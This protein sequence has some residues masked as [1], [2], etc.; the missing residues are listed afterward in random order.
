MRGL[1]EYVMTGRR[2]AI[3]IV[4]LCGFFPLL[5]YFSAAVVG[6]VTLRK[7]R[8][9][10]LM[11]LL[12]ALLPA[13]M[14]WA[15]GDT[16]LVFLALGTYGLALALRQ[17]ESWQLVLLAATAIGLV[18]QLS[19]AL[20][21]GYLAQI[22]LVVNDGLQA[23]LSQAGQGT[24]ITAQQ[25]IDLLVSFYGAYHAFMVVIC[26]MIARWWQALLY[27]PGGFRQEFHNLR[28]DPRA[29]ALLLGLILA[30]LLGVP[31]L[32]GW[33]PLFCV[34]PMFAGLAIAH[35]TVAKKGLGTPWLVMIYVTLMFMA[36]A[37]ILL[38][39]TDSVMDLRK[40][41]NKHGG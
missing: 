5:Y 38:G 36:P 18:T 14:M 28:V 9:E 25:W 41:M 29:M 30:G 12:W 6:L 35:W 20:Q 39:M 24:G 13:G 15:M 19:L 40:R 22:E 34:A 21:P 37:I 8:S 33:K 31:P 10:G 1:A 16:S 17:T 4:L 32:D 27:N 11:V 23:Q 3:I 26:L 7:G 2:Q